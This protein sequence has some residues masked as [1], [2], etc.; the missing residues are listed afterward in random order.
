M[1]KPILIAIFSL[2][3]FFH[4]FSQAVIDQNDM[5][6]IGDTLRVNIN[7][8]LDGVDYISSGVNYLWNFS[9]LTAT[10]ER[11]DTFLS[12]QSTPSIYYYYIFQ[13]LLGCNLAATQPDISNM[14]LISLT[15]VYN[16]YKKSAANFSQYGYGADFNGN[17]IPM[18]YDNPD[19]QLIFPLTYGEKDSCDYQDTLSLDTLGGIFYGEKRHRVNY[20]DGWGNIITPIDTFHTVRVVSTITGHDT[21][22]MSIMGYAT[23][24]VIKEYKWYADGMGI[25]V[26]KIAVRTGANAGTTVEFNNREQISYMNINDSDPSLT[27]TTL[28]PNPANEQT[29]LHFSLAKQAEVKIDITDILGKNIKTFGS[30]EYPAGFTTVPLNIKEL[31]LSKGTYLV[32][33][34]TENNSKTLKLQLQ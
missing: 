22:F 29:G 2:I 17:S 26:L 10:S 14:S 8:S 15:N 32:K 18:K 30:K 1:K 21:I 25:P 20:V 5:P 3:I 28:Y 16:F 24:Y 19:V 11:I 23:D 34:S 7:N 12:V 9:N 31:N 6:N 4:S 13:M 27:F 33:I